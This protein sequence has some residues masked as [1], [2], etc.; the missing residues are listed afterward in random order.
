MATD[1]VC[2]MYVDEA[3]SRLT[4]V[5]RGRTYYFCSD[6]CKVSFDKEPTKYTAKAPST[7][8]SR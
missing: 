6:E 3:T 5:V 1:P 7:S 8:N 4:A 2:G